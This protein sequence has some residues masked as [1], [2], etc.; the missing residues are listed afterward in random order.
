M[1]IV[2][3]TNIKKYFI[4]LKLLYIEDILGIQVIDTKCPAPCNL[5]RKRKMIS[6]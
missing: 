4:H 3:A 5:K 2:T 6:H 1:C